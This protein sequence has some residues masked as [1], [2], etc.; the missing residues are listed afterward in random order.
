MKNCFSDVPYKKSVKIHLDSN[1][2]RYV[3]IKIRNKFYNIYIKDAVYTCFCPPAPNDGSRY[4]VQHKDDNPANLHY[5][6]LELKLLQPVARYACAASVKITN[7]LKITSKGEVSAARIRNIS[8]IVLA[9]QIQ[10][11]CDVLTLMSQIL[12]DGVS[13]GWMT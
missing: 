10:T 1:N 5:K 2:E 8:P 3:R 7:G 9:M 12:K 13:Y 6:N 4:V 11:L